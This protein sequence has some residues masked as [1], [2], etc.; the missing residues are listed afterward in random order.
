MI[1]KNEIIN[2]IR[3][4]Q[5]LDEDDLREIIEI[6]DDNIELMANGP[7]DNSCLKNI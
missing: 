2:A 3:E 6:A 1:S 4:C 7:N 5:N